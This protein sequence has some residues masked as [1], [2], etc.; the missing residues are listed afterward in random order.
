MPYICAIVGDAA[1]SIFP[2]TAREWSFSSSSMKIGFIS[3]QGL[4]QEAEN[5]TTL[6]P[7]ATK[8]ANWGA[9]NSTIRLIGISH[10][11]LRK[12]GHLLST[13]VP[14]SIK[15]RSHQ[16]RRLDPSMSYPRFSL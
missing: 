9:L 10:V 6:L 12:R 4:H 14:L 13:P 15:F 16:C 8:R 7:L 5:I 1:I 3:L 2:K 11:V